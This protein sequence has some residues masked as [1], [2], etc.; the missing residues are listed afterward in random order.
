MISQAQ[1]DPQEIADIACASST[2]IYEFNED[3]GIIETPN[4]PDDYNYDEYCQWYINPSNGIP[5]G[6]VKLVQLLF[7]GRILYTF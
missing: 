6:Q 4:F 5:D 3:T 2:S 1:L 7:F